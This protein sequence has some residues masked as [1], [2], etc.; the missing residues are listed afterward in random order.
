MNGST[1]QPP[2]AGGFLT[3]WLCPWHRSEEIRGVVGKETPW[4]I[5]KKQR[6]LRSQVL[7][8]RRVM[9]YVITLGYII[10]IC[11]IY[12]YI[13]LYVYVH[14]PCWVSYRFKLRKKMLSQ[15]ES[16]SSNP[17]FS[18]V[19]LLVSQKRISNPSWLKSDHLGTNS[20]QCNTYICMIHQIPQN[21]SV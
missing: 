7:K 1:D 11:I 15:Q 6:S 10:V 3:W 2:S 14:I 12:I 19:K 18:G 4:C 5:L 21:I 20:Q 13:D 17:F 8:I 9:Y 16:R